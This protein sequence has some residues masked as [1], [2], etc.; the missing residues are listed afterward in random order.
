MSGRK[1]FANL[2][3]EVEANPE[4]RARLDRERQF[5]RT[6]LGLTA[7]REARGATQ[8]QVAEAWEVSQANV[9]QI[10]RTQ[11]IYLSTLRKYIAALGGQ[12]EIRAVFPDQVITLLGDGEM[13]GAISAES[14]ASTARAGSRIS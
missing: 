4:R 7:V 8:R 9:S 3:R 2:K 5:V 1:N 11:D 13:T 12:V 10:E 14:S 6:I